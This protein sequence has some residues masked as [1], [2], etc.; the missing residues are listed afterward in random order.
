MNIT[1]IHKLD[2]IRLQNQYGIISMAQLPCSVFGR[3]VMLYYLPKGATY[4]ATKR[5]CVS[6]V[7]IIEGAGRLMRGDMYLDYR[8]G[9]R[10]KIDADVLYAIPHVEQDTYLIHKMSPILDDS[11][12]R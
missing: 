9:S 6:E 3:E 7:Y 4:P 5:T 8:P 12:A 2:Y 1:S 11:V 10:F